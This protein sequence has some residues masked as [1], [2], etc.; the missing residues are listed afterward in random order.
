MQDWRYLGKEAQKKL[1][2][3]ERRVAEKEDSREE[4]RRKGGI[5]EV[6]DAKFG[7]EMVQITIIFFSCTT[8][9]MRFF[10]I[11]QKLNDNYFCIFTLLSSL[12]LVIDIF[13]K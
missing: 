9:T 12:N 8:A 11:V 6:R 10:I 3:Q 13:V 7:S 4:G 5:Q 2:I 1:G